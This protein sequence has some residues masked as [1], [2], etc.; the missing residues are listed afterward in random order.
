M[1]ISYSSICH[2]NTFHTIEFGICGVFFLKTQPKINNYYFF[3]IF[4]FDTR[5]HFACTNVCQTHPHMPPT[6][7]RFSVD[8]NCHFHWAVHFPTI[9]QSKSSLFVSLLVFTIYKGCKGLTP[10]LEE[11]FSFLSSPY[12]SHCALT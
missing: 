7:Q 11:F 10:K 9:M 12:F 8:F 1:P 6:I 4:G 3:G 2:E 5:H